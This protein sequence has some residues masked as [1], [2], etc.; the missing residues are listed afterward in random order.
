MTQHRQHLPP[1]PLGPRRRDRAVRRAEAERTSAAIV[2]DPPVRRI[3]VVAP[4]PFYQDRGT[5][6]AL[7]QVLAG[8]GR[9]GPPGGP[10]D[11]PGR[12]GRGHPGPAHLPVGQPTSAS[13]GARSACP[14][15]KVVLDVPL[16]AALQRRL[17][18][19]RYACIHAVEEAAFPAAILARQPTG[20]RCC[21]T[22][23][24]AWPSSWPGSA[25]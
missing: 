16:T 12:R 18:R 4:Q 17:A 13:S 15:R 21:T 2:A 24:R 20:F 6:I 23:S 9:A 22:C 14:S 10:R 3:L 8:P 1:E 5:P 25:R 7:R 19:E 11:L